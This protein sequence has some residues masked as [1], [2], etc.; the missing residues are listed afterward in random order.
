MT[1]T[2]ETKFFFTV[3]VLLTLHAV[4]QFFK[5]SVDLY[6]LTQIIKAVPA[7]LILGAGYGLVLYLASLVIYEKR[8]TH[9][10]A[11]TVYIGATSTAFFFVV[12]WTV[13]QILYMFV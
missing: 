8:G 11:K 10:L 7:M 3:I 6:S 4:M 12:M 13:R 2:T 1:A 5:F 9:T